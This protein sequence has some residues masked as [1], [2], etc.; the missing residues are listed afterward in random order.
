MRRLL[1]ILGL[2]LGLLAGLSQAATP[3]ATLELIRSPERLLIDVRTPDEFADG[4]LSGATRIGYEVIGQQIEAIAPDRTTP[5]V[6]Y[7]RSGRRADVARQTLLDMGYSNV[8]NAGGYQQLQ[9]ELGERCQ[10]DSTC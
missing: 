9:S 10:A 5:I 2:G 8:T 7:C 3:V 1:S 4:H 6:L